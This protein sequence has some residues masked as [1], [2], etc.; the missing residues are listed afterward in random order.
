[1]TTWRADLLSAALRAR[2][3][4]GIGRPL[5]LREQ[6]AST[7]DVARRIAA[8]GAPH[9]ATVVADTQTAGRGRAGRRWHSPP[10][11]NLYLSSVLRLALPPEAIAPL[12]LAVGLAVARAS[13]ELVGTGRA[14]VKWPNDVYLGE[15]KLAGVLVEATTRAGGDTVLIA[16][17]GV[18]VN[19]RD[20]PD[21]FAVPATSLAL[22]AGRDVDR[23]EAAAVLLHHLGD[24]VAAY[25][26]AGVTSV[27]ADLRERDFLHSRRVR[28]EGVVGEA[29]G[30][31]D[32]GRLVVRDDHGIHHFVLS[33]DVSWRGVS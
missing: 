29:N 8:E 9:G 14:A 31:D 12:A 24:V 7:N 32:A 27:V 17:V 26:A 3:Y 4:R 19:A 15:R 21:D 25:A 1:M 30:I 2:G 5:T 28:V 13:D 22:A 23:N 16:G 20:F 11:S 33:G 10:G 18:N 6:T